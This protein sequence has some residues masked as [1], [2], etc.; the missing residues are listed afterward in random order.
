[1]SS[2]RA[3]LQR[4]AGVFGELLITCGVV[5]LLFCAYQL[6][7][8]N[9]AAS[10]VTNSLVTS[11]EHGFDGAQPTPVPTAN[12]PAPPAVVDGQGFALMYIPRLKQ[13][14]WG[15]PIVQGVTLDD[16]KGA[17]G[18]YPQSQLP[19]Q[20]GNFALA[21]H[22]ATNGELF[23]DIDQLIAG[24]LV[25][26]QTDQQW[27]TYRLTKDKIVDPTDV[28]VVL[29]VPNQP[30]VAPTQKLITLTTCN[31]RWAST[32][33]W[34]WWGILESARPRADGPPPGLVI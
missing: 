24:D 34:V 10:A 1:M 20:L 16:L 26:V 5:A 30:G 3:P 19:G 17:I 15:A 8:T 27:F 13:S 33:R 31:P 6:W 28:G 11:I 23:R 32:Q 18:H 4:A 14:V 12:E 25:Y 7:W 2:S 29:A 22:R 9:I 21:A